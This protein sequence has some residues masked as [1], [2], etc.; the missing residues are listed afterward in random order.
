[1]QTGFCSVT[2]KI[3][4]FPKIVF[5]LRFSVWTGPWWNDIE[6]CEKSNFS[7]PEKLFFFALPLWDVATPPCAKT[8]FQALKNYFFRN[9]CGRKWNAMP[10][11]KMSFLA[12]P[13][14]ESG[15]KVANPLCLRKTNG[16]MNLTKNKFSG[17]Q[18]L[19]VCV[20]SFLCVNRPLVEWNRALRKNNFLEPEKLFFQHML[21]QLAALSK[22]FKINIWE[23]Q[24]LFCSNN[25]ITMEPLG[26]L[27]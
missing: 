6:L 27:S 26:T 15:T 18:K 8:I 2:K 10:K 19:F 13:F 11:F 23:P 22:S 21:A 14:V 4:K 17:S 3:I 12:L 16:Q 24:Q 1:M 20:F 9:A 7:G 5:F 25:L